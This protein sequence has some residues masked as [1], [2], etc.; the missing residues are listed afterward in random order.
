MAKKIIFILTTILIAG[1]SYWHSLN[2]PADPN[3][4]ERAFTVSKGETAEQIISNLKKENLIKSPVY[5]KYQIWGAAA[6]LKAGEYLISPKL[7]TREILKVLIDGEAISR[8]KSIRIIEGWNLKDIGAYFTSNKITG[9]SEFLG[10]AQAPLS[11]WNFNFPKPDFLNDAPR[12]ANLAGYLFPDTYR[13]FANTAAEQIIF[14]MLTNFD[15]KLTPEMRA[16]IKWQQKTIYEIVTLASI[17]E[18]EVRSID[19]M[20]IVSGIFWQR[21]K[22]GQGLESCAT[23]AHILGV[24]KAQYSIEDTKIDSPYNTYKYRG[25]PPGPIANPGL[26]ALKAAIYPEFTAYNYFLSDPATGKTIYSRSLEEHNLNKF[27]YLK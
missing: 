5:F 11:V 16:E 12:E 13:I 18:K 15:R 22:N 4:Q 3:G 25:L 7:S 19:D 2:S 21:I 1:S 23:L 24:N 6:N 26:N 8:E 20:K 9:A 27:K 10:L 17:I 14:K